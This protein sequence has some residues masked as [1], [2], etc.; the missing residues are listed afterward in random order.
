MNQEIPEWLQP[1]LER[2]RACKQPSKPEPTLP[3]SGENKMGEDDGIDVSDDRLDENLTEG[4]ITGT[5]GPV[6]KAAELSEDKQNIV[7]SLER[8][9]DI[10]AETRFL[11]SPWSLPVRGLHSLNSLALSNPIT[12]AL[13]GG[14]LLYGG[15]RLFSGAQNFVNGG[16]PDKATQ[17]RQKRL[18]ALLGIGGAIAGGLVSRGF[19]KNSSAYQ[20]AI[21]LKI[22]ND[23]S[24]SPQQQQQLMEVVS[25]MTGA[26]QYD[27]AQLLR[28]VF[29]AGIGAA[30]ARYLAHAGKIGTFG[31]GALG[32]LLASR[33]G[34]VPSDINNS[35]DIFGRPF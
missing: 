17:L 19:E 21:Q 4:H 13:Y 6:V 7:D 35:V 20:G 8:S 18:A 32:A 24:L 5:G 11:Q 27:L 34:P 3:D 26:Q 9:V 1:L 23:P 28:L 16:K 33:M 30:I 31:G 25:Q 22:M 2:V 14:G 10:P 12:G 15:S 29:G